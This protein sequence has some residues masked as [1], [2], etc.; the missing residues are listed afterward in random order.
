MTRRYQKAPVTRLTDEQRKLVEENEDLIHYTINRMFL[1]CVNNHWEYDDMYSVGAIGLCRAA[2]SYKGNAGSSFSNYAVIC[3]KSAIIHQHTTDTT[4]SRNYGK[5]ELHLESPICKGA[6][7]T[8]ADFLPS[9]MSV[10]R[11]YDIEQVREVVREYDG[12]PERKRLL[13][14]LLMGSRV[15]SSAD[16]IG[17]GSRQAADSFLHTNI[18]KRLEKKMIGY[19]KEEEVCAV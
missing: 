19:G 3:I 15:G 4:R 10:E 6:D 8:V 9:S 18:R 5:D 16:Q 13:V 2:Q 17:Y 1:S 12:I 11:A 7:D 14:D